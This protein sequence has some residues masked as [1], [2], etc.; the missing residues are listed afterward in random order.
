M[1]EQT[2]ML[3]VLLEVWT[4]QEIHNKT[5]QAEISQIRDELQAVRM[6][7]QALKDELND[8]KQQTA[9][10][11][12]GLVSTQSNPNPSYA[13]VAHTPPTSQP[14]NVRTLSSG[15][16]TVPSITSTL[17][18]TIDTSRVEQGATEQFSAGAIRAMVEEG[19][20]E[21]QHSP[22]WRCQA[23]TQTPRNQHRIRIACRNEIEH[24]MVKK[25]VEGKIARGARLLRDDL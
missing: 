16:T 10:G 13:E 22:T 25:V 18:C 3:K 21:E 6:D 20:R 7:C 19:V 11:I 12:A 15:H 9:E 8:V 4:R 23:V 1:S 5:L 14:S 2:E 24:Q 17:Y